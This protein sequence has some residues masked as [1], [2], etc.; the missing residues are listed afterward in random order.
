MEKNLAIGNKISYNRGMKEKYFTGQ[1]REWL[2]QYPDYKAQVK[3]IRE[4]LGMTQEQLAKMVDRTPRSIRTIENGEAFPRINTLQKIADALNAELLISLV[5]KEDIPGF[6][7]KESEEKEITFPQHE[8]DL[9]I[10][11]ND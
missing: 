11:E 4:T 1:T 7:K 5:P 3:K 9:R 8:D 2:T 6:L 10:G